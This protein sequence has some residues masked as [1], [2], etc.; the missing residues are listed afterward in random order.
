MKKICSARELICLVNGRFCRAFTAR[1]N[2]SALPVFG[3]SVKINVSVWIASLSSQMTDPPPPLSSSSAALVPD[4][5]STAVPG[6][7]VPGS[8]R[9]SGNAESKM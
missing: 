4:A 7:A 9:V 1:S 5:G 6:R 3:I 2:S 8:S